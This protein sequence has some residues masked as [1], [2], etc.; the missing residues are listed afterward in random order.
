MI[1]INTAFRHD[2][3]QFRVRNAVAQVEEDRLQ[4]TSLGKC[5]PLNETVKACSCRVRVRVERT[6]FD[7][8]W[9]AEFAAE[10]LAGSI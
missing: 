8:T 3:F 6:A 1:Q 9:M 7:L 10:P 5:A 4:K 2:F